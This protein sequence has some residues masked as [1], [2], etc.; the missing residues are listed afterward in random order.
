MKHINFVNSLRYFIG[1]LGMGVAVFHYEALGFLFGAVWLL[2][3]T[4][5]CGLN[6][7]D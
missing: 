4:K 6:I 1:I 5:G 7:F 2:A 3:W